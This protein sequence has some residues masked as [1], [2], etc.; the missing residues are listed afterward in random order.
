VCEREG[1]GKGSGSGIGRGEERE[2]KEKGLQY[3][4][5]PPVSSIFEKYA[6]VA[7]R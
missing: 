7:R 6:W 2:R 3:F 5:T 1:R 4:L